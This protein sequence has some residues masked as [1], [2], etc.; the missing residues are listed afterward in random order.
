MATEKTTTLADNDIGKV[1]AIPQGASLAL[2]DSQGTVTKIDAEKLMEIF[3]K[4][5]KIGVTNLLIDS[6]KEKAG[7]YGLG[8]YKL[9]KKMTEGKQYVMTVEGEIGNGKDDAYQVWNETGEVPLFICHRSS[10]GIYKGSF[11]A[12]Q[13]MANATAL[14]IHVMPSSVQS[15]C[16]IHAAKLEE[17]NIA[18]GW[19]PAPEDLIGGGNSQTFKELQATIF[20]TSPRKA[21]TKRHH[22]SKISHFT[23]C[24]N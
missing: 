7:N 21:Q 15:R 23:H 9:R 22:R 17:S 13:S 11:V 20:A 8:Q 24:L 6:H 1:T 2:I 4:S 5:I 19:T 18:T 16:V 14:N 3:R 10:D 12:T